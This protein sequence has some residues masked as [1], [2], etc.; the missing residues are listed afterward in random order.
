M[1]VFIY[2]TNFVWNDFHYKKNLARY[3][4]KC[5]S[6]FMCSSRYSCQTLIQLES[7]RQFFEKYSHIKF[8][9]NPSSGSRA[10]PGRRTDGWRDMAKL[11]VAFRHFAEA[12]KKEPLCNVKAL[13]GKTGSGICRIRDGDSFPLWHKLSDLIIIELLINW[14]ACTSHH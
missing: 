14:R 10:L 8:H 5:I 7:Y 2:S 13:I 3:C 9:K 4:F 6:V 1:C 12:P 11:T